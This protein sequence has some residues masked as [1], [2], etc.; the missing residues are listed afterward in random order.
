MSKK[1]IKHQIKEIEMN[2]CHY[3]PDGQIVFEMNRKYRE[4]NEQLKSK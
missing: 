2:I 3:N 1:E 4:L